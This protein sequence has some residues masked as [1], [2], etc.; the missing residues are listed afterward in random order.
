MGPGVL[1]D[2]EIEFCTRYQPLG[3]L[4]QLYNN[5]VMTRQHFPLCPQ[6]IYFRKLDPK[7]SLKHTWANPGE[8]LITYARRSQIAPQ[9]WA[10]EHA[11]LTLARYN[12]RRE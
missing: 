11:L 12:N 8:L 2:L 5:Y 3:S 4:W 6:P 1:I 10:K 7:S 9:R